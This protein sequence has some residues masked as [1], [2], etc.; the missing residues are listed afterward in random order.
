MRVRWKIAN[1]E[2]RRFGSAALTQHIGAEA[3][4]KPGVDRDAPLKIRQGESLYSVPAVGRSQDR[5]ER[6]VL[7]NRE[8]L[9]IAE[10]KA[11]RGPVAAK[12][13]NHAQ[14]R[15]HRDPPKINGVMFCWGLLRLLLF[16]PEG[17]S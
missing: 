11:S 12:E 15:I 8:Q 10:G 3:S 6:R 14:I 4:T 9:P 2:R 1:R 5:E 13:N 7:R 17:N 16:P